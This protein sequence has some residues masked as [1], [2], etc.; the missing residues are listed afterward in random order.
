MVQVN[1]QRD[2]INMAKERKEIMRKS[3]HVYSCIVLLI[4]FL[5]AVILLAVHFW[6]NSKRSAFTNAYAANAIPQSTV[7]TTTTAEASPPL[8]PG[9]VHCRHLA[10]LSY[11]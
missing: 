9:I 7:A 6:P 5:L 2:K 11:L 3:R 1:Y 4:L 10:K 8:Y